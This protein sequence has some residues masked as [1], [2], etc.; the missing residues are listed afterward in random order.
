MFS[1]RQ[2]ELPPGRSREGYGPRRTDWQPY[3]GLAGRSLAEHTARLV[4]QLGFDPVVQEFDEAVEEITGS[5]VP[6]APAVLLLDRWAL[7]DDRR[8][9]LVRRFDRG[10][11]PW[12]SV[13]EPWSSDDPDNTAREQEF[14]ELG[15]R[16]LPVRHREGRPTF[17][18]GGAFELTARSAFEEAVPRAV[19]RAR[20]AHLE[21][22]AAV[23]GPGPAGTR[24]PS[25]RP[26]SVPAPQVDD[27]DTGDDQGDAEPLDP[28]E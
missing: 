20:H 23:G 13:L 3:R 27:D 12:V 17:R 18:P 22:Q 19:M 9:V 24:R 1:L 2:D 7:L 10:R 28:A 26:P 15:D 21:A 8:R 5:G 6:A 14:R 11:A 16:A 25:L 4:R